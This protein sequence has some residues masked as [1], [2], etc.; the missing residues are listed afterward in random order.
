MPR[1]RCN[2]R[3]VWLG[4]LMGLLLA[5]A[6]TGVIAQD[7]PADF[8]RPSYSGVLR[9]NEDWSGL[10]GHDPATTGDWLDPIKYVPLTD[11]E[12]IWA[13]FGG[14]VRLRFEGWSD[15]NFGAPATVDHDDEYVLTRIMLHADVHVGENVRVFAEGKSAMTVPGRNLP[16]GQRTLEVDELDLQQLFADVKVPLADDVAITFRPG[17]QMLLF[18]KQRLVSPLPW[19]NTLRAWDGVSAI[20]NV[21][22]WKLHGFWTQF[23][24]VQKYSFNDA[25]GNIEFF[26]VYATGKCPVVG[27]GIDLYYLG[28][29]RDMAAIPTGGFNGTAGS[30]ERHTVGG[31]L[32]GKIGDTPLDYDVEGAYQFGDVGTGDINAFM[33]ASQFGYAITD[34]PSKPRLW[35]GFDYAS[36]DD[37]AGGDVE[38]FNQLFPLGHAYLGYIDAIGRQ[39]IYDIST[40]LT[41]KP[42]PKLTVNLAGHVFYL[43]D[44]ADALYNAGG[45]IVRAGGLSTSREVGSEIDL[46]AKYKIDHHA[47]LLFGYS[48][49]FPDDVLKNTGPSHGIDFFYLAFNYLF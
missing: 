42:L 27:V 15:F 7:P 13:S 35:M 47:S 20:L 23:A 6:P 18:G 11:D 45:G 21:G 22:D 33:V 34:C 28:L 37:A 29:D 25:D 46:T 9:Q 2:G 32:S 5:A 49:F 14:S 17:R 19:G 40:G 38:T 10:A 48:H 12:W 1:H 26:G 41:V 24:P 44:T 43:A 16:G 4:A 30:E 8:E 39:N 31:R 3:A 36:G